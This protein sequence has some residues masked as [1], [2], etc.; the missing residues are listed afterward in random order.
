MESYLQFDINFQS[1]EP[2]LTFFWENFWK[3]WNDL[4]PILQQ[5]SWR[6]LWICN[7]QKI[8][9]NLTPIFCGLKQ[10]LPLFW[11][12]L[13]NFGSTFRVYWNWYR[14]KNFRFVTS[15]KLSTIWHQFSVDWTNFNHFFGKFLE[16]LDSL[17]VF[18]W[19]DIVTAISDS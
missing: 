7:W 4:L 9:Y 2:M 1:T 8:I 5:M 14:D 10:F 3:F 18:I 19:T 16:I 6:L 12:I 15:R 17:F 11:K 13:E